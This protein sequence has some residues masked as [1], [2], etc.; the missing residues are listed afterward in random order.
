MKLLNI[1]KRRESTSFEKA[2][3]ECHK[4]LK[5]YPKKARARLPVLWAEWERCNVIRI[6]ERAN[7]G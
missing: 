7:N 6:H 3:R 2:M 5:K 4:E 1:F